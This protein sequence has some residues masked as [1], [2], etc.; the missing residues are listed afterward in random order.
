VAHVDADQPFWFVNIMQYSARAI[1]RTAFRSWSYPAPFP[2]DLSWLARMTRPIT[3][4]FRRPAYFHYYKRVVREDAAVTERIQSVAH[5]IDRSP[6]LG[7]LEQRIA[8]FE[9]S[10]RQLTGRQLPG[11]QLTKMNEETG[12]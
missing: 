9:D 4:L 12:Q 3:D 5:Q 2:A 8:W 7:A 6:R 10:I 11:Q 1:D